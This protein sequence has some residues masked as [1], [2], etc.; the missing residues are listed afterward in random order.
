MERR[1]IERK[2]VYDQR[3]IRQW[4]VI[5]KIPAGG[6]PEHIK[7]QWIG[8][9]L[10][11]RYER[12]MDGPEPRVAEEIGTY[13][14]VEIEDGVTIWRSDALQALRLFNRN[15]AAGWWSLEG[16]SALI[17]NA[18]EGRILSTEHAESE[19]PQ[20]VGFDDVEYYWL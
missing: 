13:E 1:P 6:A 16:P 19:I 10:P 2:E 3:P 20:I 8:V 14:L 4:F 12:N 11:L 9:A 5:E 17:F 15:E 18:S 7:Q